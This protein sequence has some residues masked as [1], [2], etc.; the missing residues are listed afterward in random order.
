MI[1]KTELRAS[2]HQIVM[3]ERAALD[4]WGKGDPGGF[5]EVYAD[6][7]TYFDPM[8]AARVDG[9]HAMV[10]YY[11]PWIGKIH[12][13]RYEMLNPHVVIVGDTPHDVACAKAVGAV[14]VAGAT[15]SFSVDQLQQTG[16]DVVF[17][18]LSD[19]RAFVDLLT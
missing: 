18:D 6:D 15:G 13:P 14:A 16:A 3:L 17:Q 8:T 19:T 5:L 12:I 1:E 9:H 10:D 11:E 2:S 4:R 7:I